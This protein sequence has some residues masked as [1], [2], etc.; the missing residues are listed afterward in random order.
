MKL[1]GSYPTVDPPIAT[2]LLARADLGAKHSKEDARFNLFRIK[3]YGRSGHA[4][5]VNS[6]T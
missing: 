2:G 6:K 5:I 4:D 1:G 3:G